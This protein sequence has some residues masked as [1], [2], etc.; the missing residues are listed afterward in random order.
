MLM[1][2][3]LTG[4]TAVTQRTKEHTCGDVVTTSGLAVK[5]KAMGHK[6]SSD[7]HNHCLQDQEHFCLNSWFIEKLLSAPELCFECR[8][9]G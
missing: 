2:G 1:P 8:I 5:S 7:S 6:H 9:Y 3:S 4:F